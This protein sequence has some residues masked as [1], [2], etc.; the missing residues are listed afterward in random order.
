MN[1]KPEPDIVALPECQVPAPRNA[2]FVTFSFVPDGLQEMSFYNRFAQI[3][4]LT[5]ST[6]CVHLLCLLFSGSAP[7]VSS[8]QF[9]V[10]EAGLCAF[11]TSHVQNLAE[12][13]PKVSFFLFL[14]LLQLLTGS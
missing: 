8:A 14:C 9:F 2:L 6:H 12:F 13:L 10:E 3:G 7:P 4:S 5:R 11:S 1:H